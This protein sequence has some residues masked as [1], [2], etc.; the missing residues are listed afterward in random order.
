MSAY[1]EFDIYQQ[2]V[3]ECRGRLHKAR[4]TCL[5]C[6]ALRL[7][8]VEVFKGEG[9]AP[10]VYERAVREKPQ[11]ARVMACYMPKAVRS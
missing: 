7:R 3:T 4:C 8:I 6:A 11:L 1:G 2:E 9:R 5:C 10:S